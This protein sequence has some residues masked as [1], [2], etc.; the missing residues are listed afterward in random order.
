MSE[1][2]TRPAEIADAPPVLKARL[3]AL[4]DTAR[5]MALAMDFAFLLDPERKL[6]SI[7]YS[8]RRQ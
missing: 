4:A 3:K 8:P 7:G 6:L 5:E 1:N 2:A